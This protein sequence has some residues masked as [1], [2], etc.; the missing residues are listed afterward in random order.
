VG[1]RADAVLFDPER[2]ADTATFDDPCR[3]PVGLNAVFVNGRPVLD[4]DAAT[5]ERPG[6]FVRTHGQS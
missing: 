4:G 2:F 5:G 1:A 6:V 3:Y